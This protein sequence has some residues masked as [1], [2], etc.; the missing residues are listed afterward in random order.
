MALQG[1]HRDLP[2]LL[3]M[4]SKKTRERRQF[5]HVGLFNCASHIHLGETVMAHAPSR[6]SHE[7]TLPPLPTVQPTSPE[8]KMACFI[9]NSIFDVHFEMPQGFMMGPEL[10]PG[11]ITSQVVNLITDWIEKV[12]PAISTS[13]A[14]DQA[15]FP[16]L[17]FVRLI[18]GLI[19]VAASSS[20]DDEDLENIYTGTVNSLSILAMHR[21]TALLLQPLLKSLTEER[22]RFIA[23]LD[24]LLVAMVALVDL[25][26][27]YFPKAAA[28][29][30]EVC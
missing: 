30:L 17:Y 15:K 21:Y 12:L 1:L 27:K 8:D 22:A 3:P 5:R 19:F 16:P 26:A 29:A 25:W 10:V 20:S 18:R 14:I 28:D 23:R 9:L 11:T 7:I 13:A 24:R 2:D 4:V 6:F